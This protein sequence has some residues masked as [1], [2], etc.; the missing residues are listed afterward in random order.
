MLPL[1][2]YLLLRLAAKDWQGS[3]HRELETLV[4]AWHRR[5]HPDV[6]GVV[7]IGFWRPDTDAFESAVAIRPGKVIITASAKFALPSSFKTSAGTIT[8]IEGMPVYLGLCGWGYEVEA[9]LTDESLRHALSV[10]PSS[11]IKQFDWHDE[12]LRAFGQTSP[13][14][15]EACMEAGVE[16]DASYLQLESQLSPTLREHLGKVRF[17]HR[18]SSMVGA[19]SIFD[20]LE[21]APPWMLSLPISMLMLSTRPANVMSG[22]SILLIGDL[23]RY[24]SDEV[25]KFQN[26]GRKSFLEIGQ[27]LLA[28]LAGGPSSPQARPY[29]F[30]VHSTNSLEEDCPALEAIPG[31]MF[32]PVSG[33]GQTVEY[34]F[35][36]LKPTQRKILELRMGL[37]SEPKTLH[38]IGEILGVTR[39][40]IRQIEAKA[41]L[42]IKKLPY[43]DGQLYMKLASM[44]DGRR[45]S[46]PFEGIEIL[47]PWFKGIEQNR[48]VF[49]YII[50]NFPHKPL[51]LIEHGQIYYLTDIKPQEWVDVCRAA[52]KLVE[53]MVDKQIPTLELRQLVEGLLIGSGENLREELWDE[54]TRNAHFANGKLLSYGFGADHIIKALLE[55]S[56]RPL[57][58][59]EVQK[60]LL[61]R[62]IEVEIRRCQNCCANVGLMLGRGTYGT[63]RHF[64]LSE[65]EVR[66]LVMEVEG[67]IQSGEQG[68][69]WHTREICDYFEEQDLDCNGRLNHYTLNVALKQ[70]ENLNYLG[71]MV[72]ASSASGPKTTANRLDIHQAIVSVLQEAGC[73]LSTEDIRSRLVEERGLNCYFQIQVEGELI[74]IGQGFWGLMERDVPFS[75]S[76]LDA[77]AT[78]MEKLLRVRGK[79]LHASEVIEGLLPLFPSVSKV[80]DPFLLFGVAQ[81]YPQFALAKGQ[82]LYLAEW[83]SPRRRN[84]TEAIVRVLKDAGPDGILLEEAIRR[85]ELLIERPW[86]KGTFFG[87]QACN[88]GG[89]YNSD[90]SRWCYQEV[91]VTEEV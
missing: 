29:I 10:E 30:G 59:S 41:M 1:R 60:I 22:K 14:L 50:E 61:G 89:V 84:M 36:I 71:R 65:K 63:A 76:A 17:E 70:S 49:E 39:E 31:G 73:P 90:S 68:R 24:G 33:F 9:D 80:E 40:R 86:P 77:L 44:L 67:L 2:A 11:E 28:I 57:H 75:K 47:D 42:L 62:G 15:Y 66:M 7:H 55:E 43:W 8:K 20:H 6:G 87:T 74:R 25:L 82:Y 64:L 58:F 19:E 37:N 85:V 12:W 18:C 78:A 81:K 46:L 69:Q 51:Y 23:A 4:D 26:L 32:P 56:D 38:E 54:A 45:D 53:G 16:N 88:R 52:R 5:P 35:G 27:K 83:Q 72:W 13:T 91:E 34:A 79:G 3:I 48:G 21:H